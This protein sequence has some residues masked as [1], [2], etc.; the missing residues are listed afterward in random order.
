[1]GMLRWKLS[2]E[3]YSYE[4]M[5]GAMQIIIQVARLCVCVTSHSAPPPALASALCQLV[6]VAVAIL[7]TWNRK[8]HNRGQ[9]GIST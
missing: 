2:S 7:D 5:A 4:E 1:M 6:H 8:V 9:E 3:V